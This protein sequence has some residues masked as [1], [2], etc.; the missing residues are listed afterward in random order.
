M[1]KQ[2]TYIFFKAS[3]PKFMPAKLCAVLV[4]AKSNSAGC[5]SVQSPTPGSVSNFWI[6]KKFS[7]LTPRS[8][9][10][11]GVLL[12]T[13]LVSF[14]FYKYVR[15]YSEILTYGPQIPWR[16]RCSKKQK[17]CLTP[18]SFSHFLIV[19]IFNFV[20]L[21]SVSLHRV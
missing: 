19:K 13:V 12:C 18:L 2:F 6:F 7:L 10:L 17:K 3:K 1:L 14:G 15:K 8:V 11:R 5:Q 4:W 9:I 16:W 20:P 21:R